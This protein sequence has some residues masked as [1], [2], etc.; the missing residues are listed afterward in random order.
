MDN[1]EQNIIIHKTADGKALVA[2][3]AK[4]GNIWMNQNQLVELFATSVLNIS[5]HISNILKDGELEQ[6]S[7]IKGYLTT[8]AEPNMNLT[9]W[10]GSIVRKQDIYIA[11]NYLIHD[12]IDTLN[13]L[14]VIFFESPELGVKNRMDI[15]M[16]FWR[17]NVDRILDFQDKKILTH[18]DNGWELFQGLKHFL[19]EYNYKKHYQGINRNIPY[20]RYSKKAVA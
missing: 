8:A 4:D 13:R 17:E 3:Y 1:N 14:V 18:A 9:S 5:M 19:N 20:E 6:H 15:T 16:T 7:V 11:K 10:K 2:L 12:E